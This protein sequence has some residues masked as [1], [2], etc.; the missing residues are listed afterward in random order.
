MFAGCDVTP[1][2]ELAAK[3]KAVRLRA[4]PPETDPMFNFDERDLVTCTQ[5][6]GFGE[7][8]LELRIEV[9]PRPPDFPDWATFVRVVPN[10]KMPTLEEAMA[11]AL[12]SDEAEKFVGHLR[13]LIEARRGTVRSASAYLWA[14]KN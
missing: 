8:H 5:S 3:V 14:S 2:M 13:P 10:P 7:I 1:I 6:S 9:K 12:T 11:E 4:Q